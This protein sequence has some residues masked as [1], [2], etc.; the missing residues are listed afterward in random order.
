MK[1]TK[2]KLEEL[3]VCQEDIEDFVKHFPAGLELDKEV[4]GVKLSGT[5]ASL[6]GANLILANL[7]GAKLIRVIK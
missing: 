5:K 4:F 7:S 6:G 2:E 3:G 1:I